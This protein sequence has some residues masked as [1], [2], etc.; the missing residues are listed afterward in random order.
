MI[1]C[2]KELLLKLTLAA[3]RKTVVLCGHRFVMVTDSLA[4]LSLEEIMSA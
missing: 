3:G 4:R 1:F 2:R